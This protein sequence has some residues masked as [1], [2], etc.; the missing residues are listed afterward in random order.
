MLNITSMLAHLSKYQIIIGGGL[1]ILAAG[2]LIYFKYPY[3][4]KSVVMS[5]PSKPKFDNPA[6]APDQPSFAAAVSKPEFH[7]IG[8]NTAIHAVNPP[9][10]DMERFKPSAYELPAKQINSNG[11]DLSSWSYA[12]EGEFGVP[13]GM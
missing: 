7:D 10:T 13:F 12:Q 9:E 6:F 1:L 2:L 8:G 11:S 5:A 4:M 3:S